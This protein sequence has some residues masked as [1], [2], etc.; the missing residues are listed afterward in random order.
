MV[1]YID[2]N[3]ELTPES[4]QPIIDALMDIRVKNEAI[5]LSNMALKY[6]ESHESL[7]CDQIV[8]RINSPGGDLYKLFEIFD[9]IDILKDEGVYFSAEVSS[10]AY[11]AGFYLLM[12]MDE[13]YIGEW[14]SVMYHSMLTAHDYINIYDAFDDVDK[15]IKLQKKLDQ[16]VLDNTSIPKEL[17]EKH[18]KQDLY[19]DY[20][21]CVNFGI[22]KEYDDIKYDEVEDE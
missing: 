7:Y 11:S 22:V 6:K 12:K 4:A 16:L 1:Q 13:R 14:A 5:I 20:D 17:L 21:D 8:F 19:M 18:Q 2:L 9:L 3:G 10:I 15:K